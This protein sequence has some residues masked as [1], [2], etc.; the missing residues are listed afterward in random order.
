MTVEVA[1][2]GGIFEATL[3]VGE[4]AEKNIRRLSGEA[5]TGIFVEGSVSR[6]NRYGD[7]SSCVADARL[8]LYCFCKSQREKQKKQ[9]LAKKKADSKAGEKP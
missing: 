7:T 3:R 2:G 1:P 8:R 9:K 5:P 4:M 6:L